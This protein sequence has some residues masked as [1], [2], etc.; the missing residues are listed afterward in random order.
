MSDY[1]FQKT[2]AE[3]R[4]QYRLAWQTPLIA[5]SFWGRREGAE[6]AA[7]GFDLQRDG[8]FRGFSGEVNELKALG[9]ELRRPIPGLNKIDIWV[10]PVSIGVILFGNVGLVGSSSEL[11]EDAGLGVT[12]GVMGSPIV[13]FEYTLW[14]NTE[15]HDG[16][17]GW[18]VR[19]ERGFQIGF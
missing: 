4:L 12:L 5:R 19:F 15:E 14:T 10:V 11:L 16:R 9:L 18:S 8:G 17:R 6:P 2:S 13:Y 1:T 7:Q 3:L